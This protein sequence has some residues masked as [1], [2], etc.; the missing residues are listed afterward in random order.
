MTAYYNENDPFAAAW[1]EELIKEGL[2]ADGKVDTRSIEKVQASDLRGFKQIHLFAGIGNWSLALRLAGWAD[3]RPAWT[4]SCPCPPFSFAGKSKVCPRCQSEMLIPCPSRTGFFICCSC[5]EA[6]L[7]DG[8]HL[9]PEFWRLI[10]DA[11]PDCPIFG[12]QVASEDGRVWLAMLRASLE[13]LDYGT[14]GADLCA[15]GIGSDNIRQRLWWVAHA[16][17]RQLSLQKRGSKGRDGLGPIGKVYEWLANASGKGA[18]RYSGKDESPR[19]GNRTQSD[20]G[21]PSDRMANAGGQ[22][23]RGRSDDRSGQSAGKSER[24]SRERSSGLRSIGSGLGHADGSG[25]REQCRSFPM[26]SQLQAAQ[27]GGG[28]VYIR[29]A[30]GK[31][32]A[33]PANSKGEPEPLLFPLVDHG[34]VRNRVGILRGAGNSISPQLAAEF[35]QAYEEALE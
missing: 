7:A 26:G 23:K 15:A 12:E 30:D 5:E 21:R 1:L 11:R 28:R 18:A 31:I 17:G 9:W 22:E 13:I 6:W 8:R 4:G 16:P 10:R 32:R 19:H 34:S 20:G 3:D 33:V 2:I 24:Q 14:W 35:I 25:Q 29:C 27:R